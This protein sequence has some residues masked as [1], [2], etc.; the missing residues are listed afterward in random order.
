MSASDLTS[1]ANVLTRLVSAGVSLASLLLLVQLL[2]GLSSL[3]KGLL[4]PPSEEELAA[5][6]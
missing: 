2:L 6:V 3:A 1:A 4:V 5:I